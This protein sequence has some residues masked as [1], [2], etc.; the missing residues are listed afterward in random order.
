[1][2]SRQSM[3]DPRGFVWRPAHVK[4]GCAGVPATYRGNRPQGQPA[5]RHERF[6]KR[7]LSL[8]ISTIP[9]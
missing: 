2:L 3:G 7:Q 9:Q 6:L 5:L 8:P 1:M 4:Q